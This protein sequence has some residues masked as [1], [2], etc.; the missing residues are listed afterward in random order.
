MI[1]STTQNIQHQTQLMTFDE[2]EE[3]PLEDLQTFEDAN[4][5]SRAQQQQ[6]EQDTSMVLSMTMGRQAS[7]DTYEQFYNNQ[8]LSSR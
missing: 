7:R 8:L 2:E 5:N 3:F 6:M 4:S 1:P